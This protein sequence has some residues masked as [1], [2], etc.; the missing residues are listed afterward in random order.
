MA[1]GACGDQQQIA[2]LGIV[3]QSRL[4]IGGGGSVVARC[5]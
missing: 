5:V 3:G 2:M 1:L 4:G